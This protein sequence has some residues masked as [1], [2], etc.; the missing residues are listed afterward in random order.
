MENDLISFSI[1]FNIIIQD[2]KT[3]ILNNILS[4]QS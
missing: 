3:S 4:T 2:P 1:I